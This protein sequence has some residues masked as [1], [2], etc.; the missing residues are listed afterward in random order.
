MIVD[1]QKWHQREKGRI[2]Q[3]GSPGVEQAVTELHCHRNREPMHADAAGQREGRGVDSP[4]V[5]R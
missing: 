5:L 3:S 2:D 4:Q 1:E